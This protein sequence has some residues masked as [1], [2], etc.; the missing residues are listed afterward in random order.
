MIRLPSPSLS[1]SLVAL[2]I[3][4]GG[5]GY[6]ATGGNFILGKSNS[7][8]NSTGLS[9]SIKDPTL[10][11]QNKSKRSG[12]TALRLEVGEDRPPMSVNSKR[13]V[14]NLNADLLDG[15]EA[16]DFAEA[17]REG[18]H[19]VGRPDQPKLLNNWHTASTPN[20]DQG[21]AFRV[22]AHEMVHLGGYLTGG[23][24]FEAAFR[25]P[26]NYRPI[27]NRYFKVYSGGND[28]VAV[29]S[30][31]EVIVRGDANA[32]VSLDGISFLNRKRDGF[33]EIFKAEE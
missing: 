27:F 6:S 13:R 1:I 30:T 24:L 20:G 3:S 33:V 12:A 26:A 25:L 29:M 5:A 9:A 11:I 22:D 21:A 7:A 2:L 10:R 4:L 28:S 32:F 16:S 15:H 31:G 14:A 18:W 17:F 23:T 8:G 19:Y